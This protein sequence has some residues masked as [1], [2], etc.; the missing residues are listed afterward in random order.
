MKRNPLILLL[1]AHMTLAS[2]LP[3]DIAINIPDNNL[4]FGANIA[5]RCLAFVVYG[6]CLY[7]TLYNARLFL[8]VKKRYR[9]LTL[10]LYYVFFA[11]LFFTRILQAVF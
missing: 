6:Y 4:A 1:L 8:I 5:L 10:I 3:G 2:T 7:W 9:D 11:G